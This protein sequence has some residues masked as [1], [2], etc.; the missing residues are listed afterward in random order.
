MALFELRSMA[1]GLEAIA[2]GVRC[3]WHHRTAALR[4]D[5]ELSTARVATPEL[6]RLGP[7]L[8]VGANLVHQHMHFQS[9]PPA[10]F[11][12]CRYALLVWLPHCGVASLELDL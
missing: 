6:R 10:F 7:G 2:C 8:P 3:A 9:D 11:L 1:P 12:T 4:P 5:L